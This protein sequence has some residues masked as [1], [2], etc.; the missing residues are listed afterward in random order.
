MQTPFTW[1]SIL[2]LW[3]SFMGLSGLVLLSRMRLL[4]KFSLLAAL[5]ALY[6]YY[7]YRRL[8]SRTTAVIVA[9]T[10]L[11][12]LP[13]G[14]PIFTAIVLSCLSGLL[15]ILTSAIYVPFEYI[16]RLFGNLLVA[17]YATFLFWALYATL[18]AYA[19][20]AF[21]SIAFLTWYAAVHF[22][23]TLRLHTE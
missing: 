2:L 11:L 5:S 21:M 12:F 14:D 10:T 13:G 7:G 19:F 1:E 6:V 16:M 22:V 17:A 4:V 8:F 18:D 3:S 20:T 15:W 9:V 23:T